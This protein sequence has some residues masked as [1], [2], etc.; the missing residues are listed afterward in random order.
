VACPVKEGLAAEAPGFVDDRLGQHLETL[1][2]EIHVPIHA[3]L[4]QQV[5]K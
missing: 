5:K 3:R 1:P 4:A 2:Q